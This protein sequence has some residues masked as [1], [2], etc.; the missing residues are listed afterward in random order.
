MQWYDKGNASHYLRAHP[1]TNK[2]SLVGP[3]MFIYPTDPDWLNQI[4]DISLGLN[5][6]HTLPAPI[7]H[8]D[9]KGVGVSLNCSRCTRPNSGDIQNNVLITD[10]GRAVLTDFGLSKVIEDKTCPSGN[11][12]GSTPGAIRWQAPESFNDIDSDSARYA[13][14]SDVWSF[15]CTIYEVRVSFRTYIS[16][17]EVDHSTWC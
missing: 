1:D 6:L 13:L 17:P 15:S 4:H 3:T 2:L 7:V 11:T 10:D 9:V 8:G 5:Y 16:S 12:T 14:A